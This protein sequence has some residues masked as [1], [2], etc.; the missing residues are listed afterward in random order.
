MLDVG[1]IAWNTLKNCQIESHNSN[2][3]LYTCQ[4]VPYINF[5]SRRIIQKLFKMNPERVGA[6]LSPEFK[7][8]F[9]ILPT[10]LKEHK[11]YKIVLVSSKASTKTISSSL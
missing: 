2:V 10:E 4:F 1:W 3:I 6:Q 11:R 5:P 7:K 8:R 9:N